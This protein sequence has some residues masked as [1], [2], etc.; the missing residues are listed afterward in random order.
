MENAEQKIEERPKFIARKTMYLN[1]VGYRVEEHECISG[2]LPKEMSRFMGFG[3]LA[4]TT[5]Q[6]QSL[7]QIIFPIPNAT[8]IEEAFDQ[9]PLEFEKVREKTYRSAVDDMKAE[10]QKIVIP[11]SGQLPP[12]PR[13]NGR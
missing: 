12:E 11:Q 7:K 9:M 3:Q 2:V 4:I 5:P 13:F 8:T 1:Q 10:R 6:G